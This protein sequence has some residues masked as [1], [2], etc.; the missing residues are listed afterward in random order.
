MSNLQK[1]LNV[2]A[3]KED[4]EHVSNIL[5]E[6]NKKKEERENEENQEK[7]ESNKQSLK[8]QIQQKRKKLGWTQRT[9]A[10]K[11]NLSQGTIGRAETNQNGN[12]SISALMSIATA[13]NA[14]ISI[15]DN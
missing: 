4:K 13:L 3:Q 8:D 14:T 2:L 10:I 9:L 12:I 11:S 15:E 6:L 5:N 1:A 7:K